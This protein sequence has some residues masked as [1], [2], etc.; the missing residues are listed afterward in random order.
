[1]LFIVINVVGLLWDHIE[2]GA[3]TSKYDLE[4]E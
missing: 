2:N 3:W 1:M 4:L